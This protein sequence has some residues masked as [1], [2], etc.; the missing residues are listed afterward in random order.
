MSSWHQFMQEMQDYYGID[1]SCLSK[2]YIEEQ[3]RYY[4]CTAQWSEIHPSQLL[5]PPLCFK[6][7]DLLKVT[8]DELKVNKFKN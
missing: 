1:M 6:E 3:R 2:E 7:Y 8:L 4:L 5:S